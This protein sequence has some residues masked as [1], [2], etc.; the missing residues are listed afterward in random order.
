MRI[1]VIGTRGQVATALAERAR[2]RSDIELLA[3][4]R[5]A[6]DLEHPA[7]II[8]PILATRPDLVV[9]AAAYTAVDKAESE[10]ERAFAINRDG[11]AAV[12]MAASQLGAPLV[13]LSTD[14]VFDGSKPT[15]YVE[16]DATNPLNVYG[17]SK[18][19]GEQA[20]LAA[21]PA[22][23]VLRTSWVFSP[24][25]SNFVKTML[26]LGAERDSLRIVADQI[27]NPTSAL[28][29]AE[30]ILSLAP[31]L[32]ATRNRAGICHLT[33]A[34]STS[35]HGFADAI[36]DHSAR[37]GGPKPRLEAVTT[38]DYPTPARRPSNSRLDTSALTERFGLA[39]RPW[40]EAARETVASILAD[41]SQGGCSDGT[42]TH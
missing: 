12:A 27:G 24:F 16:T 2:L 26:R 9:N 41:V 14:Y 23:L 6:L 35:W 22:S 39:L 28:D 15:P 8:Q 34:G 42:L 32:A 40:Q 7:D 13:H 20:V 31:K 21:H 25:G 1:L 30:A 10:P 4:G 18:L 38:A 36:F 19:A 33:N 3:L 5:P 11:A 29:I 37:L 17:R